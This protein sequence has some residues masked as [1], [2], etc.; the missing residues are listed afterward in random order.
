VA[1]HVE[2]DGDTAY[3][4][5]I[6]A[7]SFFE[8]ERFVST[9]HELASGW[10]KLP[11]PPNADLAG[12]QDGRAIFFL[13]EPWHYAEQ[14]F[15]EGGVVA[16]DLEN[17][18]AESV[19]EADA[20]QAVQNVELGRS[21][22]VLEYL[23]DVSG[24]AAR[25]VRDAGGRWRAEPIDLPDRGVVK[26][27]SA[28]GGTDEALLTF[29]SLTTPN[30]LY[31]VRAGETKARVVAKTPAFYDAAEI[32]VEQ[33]F[34]TSRDGTRVPY[35]IAGRKNV[36]EAGNAPTVQYAYGGFLSS[37]LPV[38]YEDPGRPQHGALAGRLWLSRGGVLVL[39]NIR[40]GAEY[41]P[42]WHKAAMKERHQ[43]AIDDFI[44]ISEALIESGVTSPDKLG[45]IGRSN[46]GLLMGAILTQRPELY[47]AI[48]CGVPLFDMRRYTKLGAGASWI[49]EYGDPDK[50]EEW[51]YLGKY[52]PYQN[53]RAER[54]YPEVF[55]YTSTQDDR[56]HPGHARKAAARM[57]EL[58]YPYLYYENTEGG[59]GGTA[60]QEQLAYR[61]ALEF[62]YFARA[63]MPARH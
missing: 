57:A 41:G 47:A 2:H 27:V 12:V 7:T 23:E 37:V 56:V 5:A 51:A 26:V 38:Y 53:L 24:R 30:A 6:R 3:V 29:E 55:F 18:R 11:L 16:Y 32:R 58:G 13:R 25:V 17:A 40:G 22:L 34:A 10:T 19:F 45:A 35:F 4:F 39:S 20:R 46:G 21:G 36:L 63:L 9:D 62:A 52:S 8:A 14:T 61:T 42:A 60:N 28:G 49:G 1:P 59:H 33:R 43:N 50:P 44:A 54:P 31:Y 48:D 15:A